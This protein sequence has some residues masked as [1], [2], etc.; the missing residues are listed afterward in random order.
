MSAQSK[1]PLDLDFSAMSAQSKIRAE[2]DWAHIDRA[3]RAGMFW[4]CLP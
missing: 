3:L 2:L 4:W 1:S